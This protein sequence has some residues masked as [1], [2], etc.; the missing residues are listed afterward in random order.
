MENLIFLKKLLVVS[1]FVIAFQIYLVVFVLNFAFVMI[2]MKNAAAIVIVREVNLVKAIFVAVV[3]AVA[4]G[5][6]VL[7]K[8]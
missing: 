2:M 3:V 1:V 7:P 6:A 8:E 5:S 4:M